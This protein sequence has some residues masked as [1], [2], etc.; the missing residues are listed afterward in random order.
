M[1]F[2]CADDSLGIWGRPDRTGKPV[3]ADIAA[4]KKTLPVIMA[5]AGAG[6]AGRRLA[7]LYRRAEPPRPGRTHPDDRPDRG[8]GGSGGGGGGG[9]APDHTGSGMP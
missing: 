4:R 1:A 8:G 5:L 2:Q 3:G 6:E 7:A 9:P